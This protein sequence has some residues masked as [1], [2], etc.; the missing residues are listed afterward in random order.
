MSKRK[1]YQAV[2]I[3]LDDKKLNEVTKGQTIAERMGDDNATCPECGSNKWWLL[4]KQS[5]AV[6]ESGKPYCECLGCGYQTH[7]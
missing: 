2:L 7:M 3:E 4:P 6:L 1:F 5:R